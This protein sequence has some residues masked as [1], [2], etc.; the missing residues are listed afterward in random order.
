[1]LQKAETILLN[2]FHNFRFYDKNIDLD[3]LRKNVLQ[4]KNFY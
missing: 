3:R 4:G 2:I 1:M